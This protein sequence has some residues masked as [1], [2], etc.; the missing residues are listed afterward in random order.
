MTKYHIRSENH[1]PSEISKHKSG[2][3]HKPSRVC[4]CDLAYL[5]SDKDKLRAR[6]RYLVTSVDGQWCVVKKFVG[7]QLCA[8]SYK[9]KCDECYLVPNEC[10]SFSSHRPFE[11]HESGDEDEVISPPDPKILPPILIKPFVNTPI[12]DPQA[13]TTEAPILLGLPELSLNQVLLLHCPRLTLMILNTS[14]PR[15]ES[16]RPKYLDDYVT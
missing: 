1:G 14:R 16:G 12:I 4:V 2:K 9:I 5:I 8:N 15:R 11:A 6:N 13:N 10:A 3:F 7:N